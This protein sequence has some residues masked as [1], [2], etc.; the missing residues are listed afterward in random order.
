MIIGPNEGRTYFSRNADECY[1]ECTDIC[2]RRDCNVTYAMYTRT[3]RTRIGGRVVIG[4]RVT[5]PKTDVKVADGSQSRELAFANERAS[6]RRSWISYVFRIE[7]SY[8]KAT[9]TR[10]RRRRVYFQRKKNRGEGAK[11]S[12][13]T[14]RMSLAWMR[15]AGCTRARYKQTQVHPWPR[16]QLECTG[17]AQRIFPRRWKNNEI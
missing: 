2:R 16:F 6:E 4:P 1:A 3:K 8:S 14:A 17:K 5:R 13:P 7:T 9:A 15:T 11:N 12:E 10:E